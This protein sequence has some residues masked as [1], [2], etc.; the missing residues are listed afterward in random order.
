MRRAAKVDANHAK[1]VEVLR[2]AGAYVTDCSRMGGGFPDLAL[3][4]RGRVELVEVKDGSKPP[5]ARKLTPDQ[6]KFH[7]MAWLKGYRVHVV[8]NEAEALEV[9]HPIE[10]AA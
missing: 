1:I 10:R 2:K 5:S 6:V 3:I 4:Y 7:E 8:K 9:L